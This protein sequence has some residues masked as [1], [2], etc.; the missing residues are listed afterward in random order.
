M[1]AIPKPPHQDQRVD[2]GLG[3]AGGYFPDAASAA[4]YAAA[5]VQSSYGQD[6]V[7]AV[8]RLLEGIADDPTGVRVV[9]FGGGDGAF[10]RELDINL[11]SVHLIDVS[12]H[13]LDVAREILA[14][15]PL[16]THLGS[17]ECFAGLADGSVDLVLCVNTLN[18]LDD[19]GQR[20]FFTE[21][22]RVLKPGGN[23]IVM[24]GNE[25]LD[26]FALNS[27]T[28]DF[29]MNN[30]GVGV[31]DLLVLGREDRWLNAGRHNP[32]AFGVLLSEFGFDEA[33]QSFAQWHE[34]PPGVAVL[35][36]DGDLAVARLAAR[37][38]T[39]DPNGLAV[40]DEWQALFRCSMFASLATKR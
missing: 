38:H 19:S 11:E 5:A 28:T 9:D 20:D 2:L 32:L 24:T 15:A 39:F 8:R 34:L 22:N 36:A 17:V 31:Q 13:M 10:L 23:L 12:P 30:F 3:D 6:R 29:F 35:R 33:R 14:D 27:G 26:L 40:A 16:T 37:N 18:Y 21:A 1:N 25:L 4:A 7:R